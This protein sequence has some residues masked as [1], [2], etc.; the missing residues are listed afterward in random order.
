M[1]FIAMTIEIRFR[2]YSEESASH[3]L[4][5]TNVG[6]AIQRTLITPLPEELPHVKAYVRYS[7]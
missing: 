7:Y 3:G 6:M 4:E 1:A 2:G 5:M